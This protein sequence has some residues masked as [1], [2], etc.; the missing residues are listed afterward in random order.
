MAMVERKTRKKLAENQFMTTIG[1]HFQQNHPKKG[2][3][4]TEPAKKAIIVPFLRYNSIILAKVE[5]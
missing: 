1:I 4:L 2:I 5:Q 3:V